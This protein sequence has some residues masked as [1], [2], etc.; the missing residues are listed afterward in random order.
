MR[1]ITY[2][3]GHGPRPALQARADAELIDI[4]T[5]ARIVGL[6]EF[7]DR[8][9]TDIVPILEGGP[10]TAARLLEVAGNEEQ[11]LR[12][13]G[14]IHQPGLV[15]LL[16]PVLK[17]EKFICIGLHDHA[18]EVGQPIPSEPMFFGKFANSLIGHG[19]TIIPPMVTDQ[20]DYEAELAVVI[21]KRGTHIS[22]DQALDYVAGAMPLND[23]SAR[24][25]QMASP[26]WTGGKA[27]DTFAPAGPALV[28][29]DEIDDLQTLAVQARVNG[30]LVQ[31]GNTANMI[32]SVADLVAYLSRIMTLLPGDIIATGTPAGVARSHGPMT[33]LQPGDTVEVEVEGLG[34]LSNPVGYPVGAERHSQTAEAVS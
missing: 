32:F 29:M 20:V 3:G 31:D 13:E 24:D 7:I 15:Q 10:G 2:D 22:A 16:P 19:A 26:L 11:R 14:G 28:L 33:F 34:V 12:A 18:A 27:I 9:L 4:A 21:G 25:L 17:P 23:V 5:L 1:L 8:P 6:R 30:T